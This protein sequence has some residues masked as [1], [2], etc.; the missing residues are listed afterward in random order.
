MKR[1]T[2]VL[3]QFLILALLVA[4]PSLV[5]AQGWGYGH[6]YGGLGYPG[7]DYAPVGFP[8]FIYGQYGYG[9]P[10]HGY[11]LLFPGAAFGY[12]YLD[13]GTN[14]YGLPAYPNTYTNPV[15]GTARTAQGT[16][17]A[18]T[19]RKPAVRN[20]ALPG[21]RKQVKPVNNSGVR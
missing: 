5:R 2:S 8:G 20:R 13:T 15:Y 19:E 3:K 1:P 4:A 11:G 10:D 9:L 17:T 16:Q 7:A 6:P 18:A 14:P 21:S 12:G